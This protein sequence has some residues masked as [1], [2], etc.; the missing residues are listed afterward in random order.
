MRAGQPFAYR[1]PLIEVEGS[2][3][4]LLASSSWA[5]PRYTASRLTPLAE[6]LFKD[7]DKDTIVEWRNNYDDTEKYPMV[8]P[9][10]G[11]YN[12][13]NGAFGIG[14]GASSSIPQYNLK[15]LNEALIKLLWNPNIEFE[16]IYCVPD[17]ATGATILNADEVKESHHNGTGFA[18]KIRS[19]ISYDSNERCLVVTEIP[20]MVYTETIC[21]ELE[22][23]INSEENPG[24]DR[25][26][27][28]TGKTPLIKIYITR[29]ANIDK[30]LK[31]LYKNTSLQ[32]YYSVNFT[33]LEDGRYPRIFTWKEMLQAHLDH[34]K[35]VYRR[36]FDFDLKK[37]KQRLHIINALIICLENINEVV[38]IIKNSPS[39]ALARGALCEKYLLDDTQAKA[40]IDMKLS[41][42]THLEVEKLVNEKESLEKDA[43]R[44][45]EIL[46]KEE[47]LNKEIENGLKEV[48]EKFG[49]A[50]RTKVLNLSTNDN[51]E[52][53]E[54]K[55]LLLNLTDKSNLFIS[56]SST[57][58]SQKR[59]GVGTK[60][61]LDK[62]EQVIDS[63]VVKNTDNL[64]F[65]SR[66]GNYY[67]LPA[68]EN[69]T[70]EK[71]YL[72]SLLNFN[73]NEEICSVIP[74]ENKQ[75]IIF[76]TRNGYVKK[77]Q[78]SE[79]N[80]KRKGGVKALTI[81]DN[82]EIC[83]ILFTD[84]DNLG[85]LTENG[86]FLIFDSSLINPVGRIA[87]GVKGI[88]L[89]ADD[90]V[91]SANII[92]QNIKE[93]CFITHNGISKRVDIKEFSCAGRYTK[94]SK[95]Q[96]LK[97]NEDKLVDFITIENEKDVVIV[98]EKAKIVVTLS[99]IPV[100]T[101][102]AAGSKTM[103]LG[104]EKIIGFSKF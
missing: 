62:N 6:Y 39:P 37:I 97:T 10:K 99:D 49:D 82:D 47:L 30:V 69:P 8:L 5:A 71:I 38:N 11:F 32:S 16:E 101:K 52:V 64:L 61:K 66:K 44:I 43:N 92:P 57:M 63:C 60:F 58:Y 59:G 26:N 23:I 7:I 19:T 31:Y 45:T 9:S 3:G 1:Y 78:L 74:A 56:E 86:N 40:I 17:F 96:K 20:Y 93:L 28:L 70:N 48:A 90:Y 102:S 14:V 65:F 42:L 68:R 88:K 53:I 29:N 72:G 18:C 75:N 89:D 21:N 79:Y 15:E 55:S 46:S 25:F 34:E 83:S 94:G 80:T 27:D 2:Y 36:G 35:N 100:L 85:L 84:K 87:R 41:R 67:N 54:E 81:D 73:S 4:T 12:L 104:E 98:S 51:D 24:I 33:M 95:V 103:K 50:R 22:E 76:V 13:V 91:C 77:S